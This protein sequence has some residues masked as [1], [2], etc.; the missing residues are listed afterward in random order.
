MTPS[1]LYSTGWDTPLMY[2]QTSRLSLSMVFIEEQSAEAPKM[3][4]I[5]SGH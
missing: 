2:G 3:A 1:G 5:H 4:S